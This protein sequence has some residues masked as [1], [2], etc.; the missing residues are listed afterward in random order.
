MGIATEK[1]PGGSR[2]PLAIGFGLVVLTLVAYWGVW[3]FG[4]FSYDDDQYVFNNPAVRGGLGP[5]GWVYAWTSFD[6]GHWQ[7]VT[8][9]SFEL[10]ATLFGVRPAA[11]HATNLTLHVCNVLLVFAVLRKLSGAVWRSALVAALFAVH[12]MHVESVAWVSERKDVLSTLFFLLTLLAYAWYAERPSWRRLAAVSA[13]MAAGLLAKT[14]LVTLPFVLLLLDY[15]P[16]RRLTPFGVSAARVDPGPEG[17]ARPFGRLLLEKLPLFALAIAGCVMAIVPQPAAGALTALPLEARLQNAC[18]AYG[19]YLWKTAV[20]NDLAVLYPRTTNYPQVAES[21]GIAALVLAITGA[22]LVT[23]RRYPYVAVGWCWFVGALVPVSGL[24]PV[25]PQLA[26]DRFTYIPHIGLFIAVVWSA[27]AVRVRTGGA[28][29]VAAGIAGVVLLGAVVVG[30]G[31]LG[32]WASSRAMWEHT[33]EVTDENWIAHTHLGILLRSEKKPREAEKHLRTALEFAPDQPDAHFELGLI[34][35]AGDRL[36]EA[37]THFEATLRSEP[38]RSQAH[39]N[40]AIAL[41]QLGREND[42]AIHMRTAL[43]LDPNSA[44]FHFSQGMMFEMKGDRTAAHRHFSEAARLNPNDKA[45]RAAAA[46]T[47]PP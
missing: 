6:M 23:G 36:Q 5:A 27:N 39:A 24:V 22:A 34:C 31:Q 41:F 3:N 9:L 28:W 38:N 43:E 7:P 25:G 40:L 42:A 45:A 35:A 21:V 19:M 44:D 11:Y 4:F 12:P 14:M 16:L 17:I 1:A 2:N 10:D 15:W 26:A 32:Y 46:R 37:A 20:P 30:R 33:A 18:T 47:G 29:P 8:W 13:A